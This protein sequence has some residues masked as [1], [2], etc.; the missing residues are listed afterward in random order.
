M[1]TA[2]VKADSSVRLGDNGQQEQY[3]RAAPWRRKAGIVVTV[4]A[5]ILSLNFAPVTQAKKQ[6]ADEFFRPKA[7][8]VQTVGELFK[9]IAAYAQEEEITKDTLELWLRKGGVRQESYGYVLRSSNEV[10]LPAEIRELVKQVENAGRKPYFCTPCVGEL[11]GITYAVALAADSTLLI[12]YGSTNYEISLKPYLPADK[13]K[14]T[15]KINPDTMSL[16]TN[17]AKI[18]TANMVEGELPIIF[19]MDEGLPGPIMMRLMLEKKGLTYTATP[20]ELKKYDPAANVMANVTITDKFNMHTVVSKEDANFGALV[21]YDAGAQAGLLMA[22]DEKGGIWV[23][24]FEPAPGTD[25]QP[26]AIQ[27]VAK[28]INGEKLMGLDNGSL[29]LL[30]CS[31]G[32]VLM[33]LVQQFEK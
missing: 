27:A 6:A 23:H 30:K 4:A 11:N 26:E 15:Q 5:V 13:Q 19:I 22:Y 33:E 32:A 3:A 12:K 8:C 31:D 24:F 16:F 21:I 25:P 18:V 2:K 9:P 10:A 20:L 7:A 17:K 29:K 28:I 14:D 1:K